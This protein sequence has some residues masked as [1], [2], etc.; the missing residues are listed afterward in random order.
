[1]PVLTRRLV[2][3]AL[4]LV[5][6]RGVLPGDLPGGLLLL[7]GILL[8]VAAADWLLAP[9]PASIEIARFAPAVVPLGGE[10]QVSWRLVNRGNRRVRAEVADELAPSL[11]AGRRRFAV[12]LPPRG[13]ATATTRVRPTRRGRFTPTELSVRSAG[14]LGLTARQARRAVPS[15]L[16]VYPSFRSR[17]EAELRVEQARVL[18]VGL[19][20]AKGRGS[21]TDFDQ[22]RDYGPDDDHRRIDWAATARTG[23]PIVRTYRA[24]RNQTIVVLLDNGR[25]MAGRVG[26]VPRVEH[27]MDAVMC[28]ST[29]A[30]RLGDK[31]GMVAF[32]RTVRAV[33]PPSARRDHVGRITEAMYDLE[34]ELLESDYRG[35]FTTTLARFRRRTMLVLL[36]DLVEQAVGESLLPALPLVA[37]RHLVVVGAVQDPDVV[38]WATGPAHEPDDVYRKAA[39]V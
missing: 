28:V 27:A 33:V 31:V 34:P 23:K 14:P 3:V 6:L 36:T 5:A 2:L 22:L 37:R 4:G 32:D 39:A 25:V 17:S 19:R 21:G 8:V 16:R 20:S 12:D 10:G 29:V 9:N 1:M 24:E 13:A 7:D 30:T 35:A 11:Q 38:R 26:G 15:I 18:E